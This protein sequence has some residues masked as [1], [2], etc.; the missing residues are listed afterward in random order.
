MFLTIK[1]STYLNWIVW[2]KTVYLYKKKDLALINLL[3]LIYHK[4][5]PTNQTNKQAI[6]FEK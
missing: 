4:S 3:K 1:L 2:N 5:Q 6:I